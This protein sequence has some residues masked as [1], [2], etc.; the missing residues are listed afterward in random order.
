MLVSLALVEKYKREG[1][2]M[3]D[4]YVKLLSSGGSVPPVEI[5]Q[6][7]GIDVTQPAFYSDAFATIESWLSDF[8]KSTQ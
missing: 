5:L 4:D 8:E 6:S 2:A 7:I 1:A 3:I